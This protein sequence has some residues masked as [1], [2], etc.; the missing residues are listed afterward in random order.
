V[1]AFIACS[2]PTEIAKRLYKEMSEAN[3]GQASFE[4]IQETDE[5]G[6]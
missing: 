3:Q 5:R 4:L 2:T 1:K 6:G